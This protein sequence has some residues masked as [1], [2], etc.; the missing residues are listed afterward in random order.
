MRAYFELPDDLTGTHE[1]AVR[2]FADHFCSSP[3]VKES[4]NNE[5]DCPGSTWGSFLDR[6]EGSKSTTSLA[7]SEWNGEAWVP[8]GGP[9]T[10]DQLEHFTE[11]AAIREYDGGQTREEAERGA[12]EDIG[13]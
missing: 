9:G 2:L 8:F 11:R 3:V 1:D 10:A 5:A 13:K 12:L 6:G 7:T 4:P